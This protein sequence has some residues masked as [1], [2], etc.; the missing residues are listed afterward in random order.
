MLE[1]H[2]VV[3]TAGDGHS[4]D[5][6]KSRCKIDQDGSQNKSGEH[7]NTE[8]PKEHGLVSFDVLTILSLDRSGH[9]VAKG[10]KAT[11]NN[12]RA[13]DGP[14]WKIFVLFTELNAQKDEEK[15][16]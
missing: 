16:K 12:H 3:D 11:S 13:N 1:K 7:S 14:W 4:K 15:N 5:I 2:P 8:N 9:I 6:S 10:H